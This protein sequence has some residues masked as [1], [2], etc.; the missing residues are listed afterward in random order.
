MKN[1]FRLNFHIKLNRR[2]LFGGFS[3][4]FGTAFGL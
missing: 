3:A 1:E 2:Y 4:R